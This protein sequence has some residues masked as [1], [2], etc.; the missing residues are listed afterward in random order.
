MT[1]TW[2]LPPRSTSP[3]GWEGYSPRL[4]KRWALLYIMTPAAYWRKAWSQ[5]QSLPSRSSHWSETR[6]NRSCEGHL[7][8]TSKLSH[9][10]AVRRRTGVERP[11]YTGALQ[12][13]LPPHLQS[14]ISWW[15]QAD[16]FASSLD[17]KKRWG[18]FALNRWWLPRAPGKRGLWW[19]FVFF[20][21]GVNFSQGRQRGNVNGELGCLN[22]DLT[23]PL[24][25]PATRAAPS[26]ALL[27]ASRRAPQPRGICALP[28]V[29]CTG[30][31]MRWPDGC[32]WAGAAGEAV[33]SSPPLPWLICWENLVGR[34]VF[35]FP[36]RQGNAV[37]TSMSFHSSL[38]PT[39]SRTSFRPG[40]WI[41]ATG[42]NAGFKLFTA[43]S[44]SHEELGNG[45]VF[46]FVCFSFLVPF[47]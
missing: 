31:S 20:G 18:A 5:A 47:P 6:G 46:L 24:A 41:S 11:Y 15:P 23:G 45:P 4:N 16:R 8:P 13:V 43:F 38:L 33:L 3:V 2:F 39:A 19:E 42:L 17:L 40:D 37:N 9:F 21:Q 34:K 32:L 29:T 1:K 26:Q 22:P 28:L 25:G 27:A 35:K 44:V 7:S 36:H 12:Q 14:A 30:C 10:G